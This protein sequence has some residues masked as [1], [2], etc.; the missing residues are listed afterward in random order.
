MSRSNSIGA[1]IPVEHLDPQQSVHRNRKPDRF[2]AV[3]HRVGHQFGHNDRG[4]WNEIF[5]LTIAEKRGRMATRQ[6]GTGRQA[7]EFD[8]EARHAK[9]RIVNHDERLPDGEREETFAGL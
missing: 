9:A 5:A 3:H 4:G 8:F 7:R 6:L 1:V 2:R